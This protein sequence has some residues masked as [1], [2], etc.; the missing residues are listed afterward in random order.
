M[1]K[2]LA[3]NKD[4]RMTYCTCSP[5]ERGKGRC[6]HVVHQKDGESMED[7]TKRCANYK[8]KIPIIEIYYSFEIDNADHSY[9]IGGTQPKTVTCDGK[10]IKFDKI[11]KDND[12]KIAMKYSYPS[13]QEAI[14]SCLIRNS[15]I[16]DRVRCADYHLAII[17]DEETGEKRT[18]SISN[19]FLDNNEIEYNL[20]SNYTKTDSTIMS[21]NNYRDILDNMRGSGAILNAICDEFDIKDCSKL[22]DQFD[23]KCA[24]DILLSNVDVSNNPMNFTMCLKEDGDVDIISMDYGRCICFGKGNGYTPIGNKFEPFCINVDKFEEDCKEIVKTASSVSKELG[25]Y[26]DEVFYNLKTNLDANKK[27][28]RK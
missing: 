15:N 24:V 12:N 27:Y 6:N 5:E 14:S 26:A 18:A 25:N 16:Q 10:F 23:S 22:K 2:V 11:E 21:G 8:S 4:G 28:W 20:A 9:D 19:N 13:I 1:T 3:L 17:I 7:F